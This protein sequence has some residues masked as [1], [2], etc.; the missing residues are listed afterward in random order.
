MSGLQLPAAALDRSL[1]VAE[2]RKALEDQARNA[3]RHTEG[4][5]AGKWHVHDGAELG[6]T[7]R[8]TKPVI[9]R[10]SALIATPTERRLPQRGPTTMPLSQAHPVGNVGARRFVDINGYRYELD[11]RPLEDPSGVSVLP[12]EIRLTDR[13]TRMI[14]GTRNER[15]RTWRAFP[16]ADGAYEQLTAKTARRAAEAE[17]RRKARPVDVLA[18]LPLL[19][20]QPERIVDYSGVVPREPLPLT[21]PPGTVID[22]EA[23]AALLRLGAK[24][25]VR[26]QAP[27]A[28]PRGGPAIVATLEAKGYS[29]S[30][31]AGGRLLVQARGGV[32]SDAVLDTIRQ[33]HRLIVAALTG[34]AI[35]CELEHSGRAPEAVTLVAVDVAA[36]EAHASGELALATTDDAQ[37]PRNAT[38]RSAA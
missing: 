17:A 31:V 3:H 38:E 28:A 22:G 27:K 7:H 35:L 9:E 15:T 25:K 21:L 36:C 10:R 14:E 20:R 16:A 37:T 18:R 34:H 1:S 32:L 6:H 24:N 2:R 8:T 11:P 19:A 12:G 26:V 4:P 33:A 13:E 30:I 29:L 23:T 5:T